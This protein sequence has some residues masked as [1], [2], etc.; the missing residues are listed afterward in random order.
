MNRFLVLK[1]IKAVEVASVSRHDSDGK[2]ITVGLTLKVPRTQRGNFVKVG[3]N[4]E[5]ARKHLV[6]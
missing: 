1:A 6:D 3:R 5:A 2:R 4:E